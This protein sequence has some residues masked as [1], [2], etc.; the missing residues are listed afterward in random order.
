MASFIEELAQGLYKQHG[1]SIADLCIVFP[2]QRSGLFFQNCLAQLAQEPIWAPAVYSMEKFVCEVSGLT[3]PDKLSLNF[4]LYETYCDLYGNQVSFDKFYHWGDML[5][6]DFNDVDEYGI[7]AARL[8]TVLKDHKY[9]EATFE[10]LTEEEREVV[11]SFWKNFDSTR[12]SDEK[13]NFIRLWEKLADLYAGFK[14][15]IRARQRGYEGMIYRDAAD[16]IES[17][18]FDLPYAGMVLAGFN[19]LNQ[20]E[21]R[22]FKSLVSQGR[23]Q[24][25][26]DV[27]AY[28]MEDE[29]QEAGFFFRN[30]RKDPVL[31]PT[32][33]EVLPRQ[34]D[35]KAR[36]QV[37]M[38]GVPLEVGQAKLAGQLLAQHAAKIDVQNTAIIL[39]DES[40]LFPVLHSLPEDVKHVNVTMG[41]PLRNSPL[42][43]FIIHIIDLQLSSRETPRGIIHH[44]KL[45]Q[46]ILRHPLFFY[47]DVAGVTAHLEE[48]E[49]SKQI[50]VQEQALQSKGELYGK[51]FRK[52]NHID[53]VFDYVLDLLLNLVHHMDTTAGEGAP[54][55]EEEYIY[56]YF[57]QI[58]RLREVLTTRQLDI[59]LGTFWRLFRQVAERMRLPFSGEPIRGLQLMGILESRNLDFE[60]IFILSMNEA[61]FPPRHQTDSFIPFNLRKGFGM[62]LPEHYD[63]MYAY[64]FYRLFH[65]SKQVFILHNTQNSSQLSGELSRLVQQLRF[66][67]GFS[68]TEQVLSHEIRAIAPKPIIIPKNKAVQEELSRYC[69]SL[70]GK[71]LTPSALNMYLDCPVKFYFQQVAGLRELD[72]VNE[73]IDPSVF[74]NLLHR[75]MELLYKGLAAHKKSYDVAPGDV[76]WLREAVDEMIVKA[77]KKEFRT[78]QDTD[79]EFEGRNLIIRDIIKEYTD[80]ALDWDEA[81]APFTIEGLEANDRQ[82][83]RMDFPIQVGERGEAFVSLKGTIDRIDRKEDTVRVLDYKSGSDS[84]KFDTLESLFDPASD[85]RNKAAMQVFFYGML[86]LETDRA[87]VFDEVHAGLVLI[88]RLFDPK[89][90]YRLESTA[91]GKPEKVNDIQALLPDYK[92]YLRRLL[93]E[94]FDPRI[95]FAQTTDHKKC[96]YCAYADIC[97]RS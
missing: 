33:P 65:K 82:G 57:T 81:Y 8:F 75:V 79:F 49:N 47:H 96:S 27:D 29:C 83:F 18:A 68:I 94:I 93:E 41:Y 54:N 20:C 95:P 64:Y 59:N 23:A 77:F 44:Y 43:S 26:W 74:G 71:S 6:N 90:D 36:C 86:Y 87:H 22:I 67:S 35:D 13:E 76:E 9:I 12:N 88:K 50:W 72:E 61:S 40:L 53:E 84:L 5:L 42:Y 37:S 78:G 25:F 3:K 2:N 60:T 38:I 92:A 91:N 55:L 7:D 39:P 32:F 63:A 97:H 30:Y 28:Y 89:F 10:G 51:I 21:E 66:E 24:V 80:K 46:S 52:I 45:V 69:M 48:L 15:K 56:Q 62:P 17:K 19:A 31:G 58:K 16:R 4:D 73:E 1:N 70:Q 14:E 34:F 11:R 85:K